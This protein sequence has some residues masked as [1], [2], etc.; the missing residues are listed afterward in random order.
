VAVTS[1][2]VSVNGGTSYTDVGNALTTNI[3]GRT[4]GTV[5]AVRVRGKDA[6]GNV[7]APLSLN[8]TLLNYG[9]D[10][11]TDTVTYTVK[12]NTGS[13]QANT[14]FKLSFY[15][16]DTDVFVVNKTVTTNG[17][18]LLG[19]VRDAA[20]ANGVVYDIK[21]TNT[22]NNHKGIFIATGGAV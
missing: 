17:L 12:N 13:I 5:D 2:E 15:R 18:G 1:Y 6:A 22:T 7:S 16:Q 21:I 3:T 4:A 9:V 10:L 14:E 19:I 8:V 11:Q 20:L